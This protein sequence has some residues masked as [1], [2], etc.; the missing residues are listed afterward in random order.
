MYSNFCFVYYLHILKSSGC[1][2]EK[3]PTF[4]KSKMSLWV[5]VTFLSYKSLSIFTRRFLYIF[6]CRGPFLED[7]VYG[8]AGRVCRESVEF[9][10]DVITDYC[11]LRTAQESKSSF[12]ALLHNYRVVQVILFE[13]DCAIFLHKFT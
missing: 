5:H 1:P 2:G 9:S 3:G 6:G 11:E 10:F 13:I 12:K 7:L 4:R 8:A